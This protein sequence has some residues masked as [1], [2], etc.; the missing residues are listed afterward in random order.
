MK[1]Y[2]LIGY[3]LAQSFSQKYF[4]AKFANEGIDAQYLNFPI[5][6]IDEF[7]N[8]LKEHPFIVG[9]NVTIPYK[10]Q[11]MR[12][13]NE[14][15]DV[16]RDIAAVNVIKLQWKGKT[17]VLKG[18]NTDTIGFTN[19]LKPFLK[20][21]HNKALILGTGGAAKSVAYSLKMLGIEYQYVSRTPKSVNEISYDSLNEAEMIGNKLIINTSPLGMFPNL[22]SYPNIPYQLVTSEHLFYDLVYNPEVTTFLR[23]GAENGAVIKNGLEMLYI[24]AEE[25]WK[26]WNS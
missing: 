9:M 21:Y 11:V 2:G 18:F 7:T 16:A 26:I 24:Q 10:E 3:P 13:L 15:D 23:K 5:P 20:S 1:T 12:Y 19:S 17:P 22:D 14:L 8:L 25:A 4:S 6:S